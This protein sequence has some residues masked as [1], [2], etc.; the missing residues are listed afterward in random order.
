M[1]QHERIVCQWCG[2]QNT[3]PTQCTT[4]GAP[5][6]V[7]DKVT[8]SGWREAPRLRDMAQ[9]GFDSSTC[10]VEGEIVPVVEINLAPT[11]AVYFEHHVLLWKQDSVPMVVM[12][13]QGPKRSL[14]SLPHIIS[15]AQGPG[16]IAFSRDQTGEIVV[17][18]LHPGQEVDVREHAFLL[19]SARVSYSYVRIQGLA[20]ILYGGNGMWLDR[21]VTTQAPGLL[22][23]HGYGNVFVRTLAPGES[24]QI[25]PGAMLFK[26]ASVRMD[27]EKIVLSKGIF[28][29]SMYLARVTG[30]GRIGIQSMYHHVAGG[31]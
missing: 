29:S 27:T 4:C 24:L 5:L 22:V 21:F 9:F 31:E 18:P 8:A 20:N 3:N 1:D 30:P 14:F 28:G 10:Q 16:R 17:L 6:D 12:Q 26:D 2:G 7:H 11:D 15:I 25:E 13:Q 19:A 23:L